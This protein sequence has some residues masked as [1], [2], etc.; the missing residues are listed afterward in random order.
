VLVEQGERRPAYAGRGFSDTREQP[1]AERTRPVRREGWGDKDGSGCNHRENADG[2][3][4]LVQRKRGQQPEA[5]KR[6]REPAHGD[7][8][9]ARPVDMFAFPHRHMQIERQHQQEQGDGQQFGFQH[10]DDGGDDERK[11]DTER[12]LN[13][14]GDEGY[15]RQDEEKV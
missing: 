3:I 11:A 4:Q 12:P 1:D 7:P 10:S 15:R 9:S 8:A 2:Q 13:E 5:G 6:S 14:C